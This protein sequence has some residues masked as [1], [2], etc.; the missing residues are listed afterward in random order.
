MSEEF[1]ALERLYCAGR[2]DLSY[3]QSKKHNE[4]YKLI[5]KALKVLNIIREKGIILKEGNFTQS[6]YDLLTEVLL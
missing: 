6:E 2:L 3:V 4:D 1:D 5:E